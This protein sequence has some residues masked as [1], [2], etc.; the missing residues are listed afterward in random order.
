MPVLTR[1]IPSPVVVDIRPGALDDLAS[2]LADQRISHSGR[3]AVAVSGGSGARLRERVAPSLPGAVWYE[4]GGGTLDDAV[5]LAGEMKADHY[6]AVVGLGGGKI[7]DC[8]KFAAARVGLP[9][10]AVPT[11]LAHDGLCSPVATLDND[12][13]RGSYGVPNPIAA[14]IDLDVIREA[15]ARF[16]RAGIGDAISNINAVADWELA[17]RINGEQIDGLAAAMARQAGEA[18]LRHP[19]GIGDNTFL[20]VLA[21]ALVLTGVAM[22]I[23]GDSRP[24]S[25]SCHEINH[26]FDLLYPKRAAAHGEQCGLGAAFAMYLRGAHEE[27][28]YMA[29]VLRRHGLPVLPEELGFTVDEFVRAVEF[30]PET[31]PG[32][33]TILEH[34]Q[35]KTNQIKDIYADYVKAIGS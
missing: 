18:V 12:A 5:R 34:L 32:R 33:Y 19:G 7:I 15:P 30:A 4:V 25:G 28:A 6:D 17:N 22:S 20:Q 24:A 3:L 16:V 21:E 27:S 9:L 8:A 31:R 1:L 14:V 10:V 35:L 29:E 23:S 2:V 26:A 11:N 13:G